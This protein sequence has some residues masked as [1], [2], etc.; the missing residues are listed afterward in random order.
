MSVLHSLRSYKVTFYLVEEVREVEEKSLE[1]ENE[2]NPLVVGGEPL[3]VLLGIEGPDANA[4]N[5]SAPHAAGK[6][7]RRLLVIGH[8][9]S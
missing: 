6:S 7:K 4:G 2:W 9:R 5:V 8:C 1:K 3:L